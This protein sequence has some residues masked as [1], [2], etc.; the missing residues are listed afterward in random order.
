MNF[1][2]CNDT[3][4]CARFKVLKKN[5]LPKKKYER[6]LFC[7]LIYR[8]GDRF[9]PYLFSVAQ[10]LEYVFGGYIK[11]NHALPLSIKRTL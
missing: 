7:R 9:P 6:E 10:G 1:Y 3:R 2:I 5:F 11:I 4:N 8:S